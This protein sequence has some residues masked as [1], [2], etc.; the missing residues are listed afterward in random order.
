MQIRPTSPYIWSL[1]F[2]HFVVAPSRGRPGTPVSSRG[3]SHRQFGPLSSRSALLPLSVRTAP[4]LTL[5]TTRT[6]SAVRQWFP[7]IR[8]RCGTEHQTS[9]VPLTARPC[10]T[11]DEVTE[12]GTRH[13]PPTPLSPFTYLNDGGVGTT[14]SRVPWTAPHSV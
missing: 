6:D 14:L 13:H 3:P 8:L 2:H 1:T 7:N 9:L 4:P 5:T 10:L 11:S 12:T